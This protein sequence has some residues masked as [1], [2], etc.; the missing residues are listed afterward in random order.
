MSEALRSAMM[1]FAAAWCIW[2]Y[3]F[4]RGV[5]RDFCSATDAAGYSRALLRYSR[6]VANALRSQLAIAACLVSF[7]AYLGVE[8]KGT[9]VFW[10]CVSAMGWPLVPRFAQWAAASEFGG[11]HDRV[12]AESLSVLRVWKPRP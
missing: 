9:A 3:V 4:R 6:G 2:L 8:T 12:S 5:I 7:L 10:I 1:L 11:V